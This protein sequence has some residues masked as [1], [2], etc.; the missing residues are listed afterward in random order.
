M[1]GRSGSRTVCRFS[2]GPTESRCNIA[3][4]DEMIAEEYV[5]KLIGVI[6]FLRVQKIKFSWLLHGGAAGAF[7]WISLTWLLFTSSPPLGPPA[8]AAA[9]SAGLTAAS[10][11]AMIDSSFFCRMY[12]LPVRLLPSSSVILRQ[13]L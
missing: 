9:G 10:F 11:E 6:L 8:S 7:S 5:H 4:A 12:S 3:S 1:E 13:L 2:Q